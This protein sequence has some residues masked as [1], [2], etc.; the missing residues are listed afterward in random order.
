[1]FPRLV[2]DPFL[3]LLSFSPH[4]LDGLHSQTSCSSEGKV[5]SLGPQRAFSQRGLREDVRA[6]C[7]F[8]FSLAPSLVQGRE[9]NETGF[10]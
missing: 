9:K 7:L 4:P 8:S 1:M 3:F 10:S 2:Q 6:R 5:S